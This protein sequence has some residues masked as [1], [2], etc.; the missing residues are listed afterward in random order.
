MSEIMIEKWSL[1]LE[2]AEAWEYCALRDADGQPFKNTTE[3]GDTHVFKHSYTTI[4]YVI[5]A[6]AQARD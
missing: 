5:T 6:A 4:C 3:S 2:F 1:L